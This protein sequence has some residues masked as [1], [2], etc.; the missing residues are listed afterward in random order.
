MLKSNTI[1]QQ[2]EWVLLAGIIISF[3]T[4]I[5]AFIPIQQR[6][7]FQHLEAMSHQKPTKEGTIPNINDTV[8]YD[9]AIILI[10][11]ALL[12]PLNIKWIF[13]IIRIKY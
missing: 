5:E 12:D 1:S 3:Q 2:S 4:T 11:C 8:S 10:Q 6:I 9:G 13:Q 7:H